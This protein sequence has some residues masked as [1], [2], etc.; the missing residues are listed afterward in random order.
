MNFWKL[1]LK[2]KTKNY[3]LSNPLLRRV[4]LTALGT[5]SIVN[6]PIYK[7]AYQRQINC[8]IKACSEKP[9]VVQLETT[10]ACNLHCTNCPHKDMRRRIGFME[11]EVYKKVIDGCVE[12]EVDDIY[13]SGMGEPTLHKSLVDMVAYAKT[14]GVAKLALYTNAT[15]LTPQLSEGLIEKGLDEL[16]VSVDAAT[17]ET[18]NKMRPPSKLEVVEENLR[19][20]LKL[21]I[22]L[23]SAKPQVTVKFI[24]KPENAGEIRLFKRKWRGLADEIYIGFAH[25]WGGAIAGGKSE[26]QGNVRRSPCTM[27]FRFM[28]ILWDG[29]MSLC[30]LDSEG[31]IRLG[32]IVGAS[33]KEMWCDG[34]LQEI[35]QAH[36]DGN[37][38]KTPLCNKCSFRDVWWL[39]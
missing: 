20:L 13:L 18:Y 5:P 28:N 21:R 19:N 37:F 8:V 3:V 12:L 11:L 1:G 7:Y 22:E 23:K 38:D 15:L 35:R 17:N 2:V 33:I 32:G 39:Y 9:Q 6:N 24:K 10:N 14:S 31:K 25:N 26:W 29:R 34:R 4:A 16:Y 36:L 27:I 30:C